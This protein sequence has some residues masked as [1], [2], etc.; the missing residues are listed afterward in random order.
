MELLIAL[1]IIGLFAWLGSEMAKSRNRSQVTWGI[2]CAL[3][4]IFGVI[5]LALIG[6]ADTE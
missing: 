4:G 5:V 1:I 3:F 2:L 6:K